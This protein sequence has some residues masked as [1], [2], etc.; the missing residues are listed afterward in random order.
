MRTASSLASLVPQSMK[1]IAVPPC[2][3][4]DGCGRAHA[5]DDGLGHVHVYD[6]DDAR[7][8]AR[9]HDDYHDHARVRDGGHP[10][11]RHHGDDDAPDEL[12]PPSDICTN[13]SSWLRAPRTLQLPYPAINPPARCETRNS[14]P[15]Q[16]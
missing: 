5:R 4:E 13:R 9:D 7:V 10:H 8:H 11:A 1:I 6:H 2:A 15:A 14:Q 3:H 12:L 16:S